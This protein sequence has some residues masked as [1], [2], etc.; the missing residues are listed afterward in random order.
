MHEFVVRRLLLLIPVMIG[1]AVFT[2]A[3]AQIIPGDPAALQCGDK[4]GLIVGYTEDGEPI[5]AHQANRERLRLDDPVSLQFERY[6]TDLING[7]WGSRRKTAVR[8]WT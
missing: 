1:V 6:I 8:S 7:D 5:T 3:V 4:C 2:F